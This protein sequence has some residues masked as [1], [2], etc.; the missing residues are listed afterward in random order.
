MT[1]AGAPRT[2]GHFGLTG[3]FQG[4]IQSRMTKVLTIRLHAELLNRAEARA[5]RLGMD[6]AKYV[7]SLIEEDLARSSGE[8]PRRFA[9]EDLA[10][11]YRGSGRPATNAEARARLHR[12]TPR[13]A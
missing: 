1:H 11:S 5:A 6:R 9:S 12:R 10:G 8:V 2:A 13:Q 7:R 3:R 4:C